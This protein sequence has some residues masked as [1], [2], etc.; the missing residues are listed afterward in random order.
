MR[1]V[2]WFLIMAKVTII[3]EN[4]TS[5]FIERNRIIADNIGILYIF[6][7]CQIIIGLFAL[8]GAYNGKVVYVKKGSSSG[9]S[10]IDSALDYFDTKLSMMTNKNASEEIKKIGMFANMSSFR[11]GNENIDRAVDFIDTKMSMMTNE[12]RVRYLKGEKLK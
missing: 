4:H 7:V 6:G 3:C 5:P 10:N 11:R 8:G 9:Y 12:N 1:M 2:L